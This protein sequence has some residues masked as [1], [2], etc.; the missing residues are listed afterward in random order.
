MLTQ[1]NLDQRSMGLR[2][3][4]PTD[5]RSKVGLEVMPVTV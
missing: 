1:Q 5:T 3:T 4:S 2:Q